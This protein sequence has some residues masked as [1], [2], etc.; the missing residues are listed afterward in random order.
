[1]SRAAMAKD[2]SQICMTAV[3]EAMVRAVSACGRGICQIDICLGGYLTMTDNIWYTWKAKLTKNRTRAMLVAT[4][5]I[6]ILSPPKI[7]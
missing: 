6:S 7:G 4:K 1:M 5:T 3:D 2:F